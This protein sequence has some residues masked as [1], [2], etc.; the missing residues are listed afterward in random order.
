MDLFRNKRVK[1]HGIL[2]DKPV[3]GSEHCLGCNADCCRGFPS[4]EL[5]PDEYQTLE[6]LGAAR[7]QFLLNG[8][9]YLIIE[10]G[11][12]FLVGNRCGI[13]NQRPSICQRF[14]CKEN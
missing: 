5:T 1:K 9:H 11:C 8:E 10:N 4:V 14:T 13:Y 7:L 3:D 12:E 2:L 6:R